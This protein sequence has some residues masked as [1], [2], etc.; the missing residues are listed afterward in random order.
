M[1]YGIENDISRR[2]GQAQSPTGPAK[3]RLDAGN[4][5]LHLEGFEDVVVRPCIKAIYT[6]L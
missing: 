4:E 5:F 6:V 2:K 1:G 3:Q